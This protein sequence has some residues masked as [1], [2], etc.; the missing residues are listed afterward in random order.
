MKTMSKIAIFATL[1]FSAPIVSNA[2]ALTSCGPNIC[3]QYDNAQS[4]VSLYGMP[5]LIGDSMRFLPSVFRVESSNTTGL[6]FTATG[7]A[8]FIFDQVWAITPGLEIGSVQIT[9][10]GD[11]SISGDSAGNADTV[12]VSLT[13]K[14]TDNA[15]SE[16][17]SDTV[18]FSASGNT[19]GAT[20]WS[21][22]GGAIS[23]A[24]VFS[25]SVQNISISI[26]NALNASTDEFGGLAWIQKKFVVT[27][28]TAV[29][30]T[31]VPEPAGL[32]LMLCGMGIAG[33]IAGRRRM[34]KK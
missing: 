13:T 30:P 20:I 26:Q 22:Q 19:V 12:G 16:S 27:V 5:T 34:V 15:S 8:N 11:Y 6:A 33:V 1:I 24:D 32:M 7:N 29:A 28:G 4:A 2:T 23:P 9:E 31:P 21:L 10:A 3:Y 18:N 25:A 14:V 17:V